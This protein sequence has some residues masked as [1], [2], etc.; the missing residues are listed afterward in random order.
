MKYYGCILKELENTSQM[1]KVLKVETYVRTI[2]SQEAKAAELGLWLT[3]GKEAGS[4]P[5]C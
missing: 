2:R 4:E 5:N 3:K 1:G